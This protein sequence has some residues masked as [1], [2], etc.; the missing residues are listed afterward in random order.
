[1]TKAGRLM[2]IR[3]AESYFRHFLK[4]KTKSGDI[5]PFVMNPP[6]RRL[7]DAIA[8]QNKARKPVRIIILKAR[9]MGFSTESEAQ[10]FFRTATRANVNSLIVAHREDSTTNLFRMSKL[11]YDELPEEVRPMRKSS[12]AQEIIFENPTLDAV[13]KK[14]NPGLRSRIRCVTAGGKGI[15]RSDTITNLHISEYAFWTGDKKE[16]FT[17]LMQ[18]VPSTPESM[19]II[20]STANG[21]D[22][23]KEL[24]DMAVRKESD[25]VPLFFAWWEMPEYRMPVP[26]GTA[27]TA[28]ERELKERYCLNDEQLAWRRWCIK[29]NCGGDETIFR[30]EYPSS[31]EEAFISTGECVFNSEAVRARIESAPEPL[32]VGRFEY[33]YDG[34][35]ISDASI[36]F[37]EDERG[38]IKLYRLPEKGRP[39]V[40]GGDTAGDGSDSFVGQVL[41]NTDGS[42]VAVLRHTYDEDVYARQMYCLGRYYNTALIGIETNYSTYPVKELSRLGYSNMYIREVPDTFTGRLKQAYGF[43]TNLKTRPVIIA[44]LVRTAREDI[45]L[46]CDK[47]TL[48][49]MLTFVYNE[50]RRPEAMAGE[51]DDCVMALAI[52]HYIRPHQKYTSEQK[53]KSR[54]HWTADMWEDYNSASPELKKIIEKKWENID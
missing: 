22:H 11:F 52:A 43:E 27:W 32:K 25:F 30:Q 23:F 41:D 17:G 48:C 14:A 4:I 36:T 2:N 38:E 10:L 37:R 8:E 15:G 19:V 44:N 39:Y 18:A 5:V 47:V 13:E 54:K 34:V 45:S 29:N 1:M 3:H 53:E 46:I 20:E 35:S 16:T 26:P 40:I 49:E 42:Q 9:Q 24:W 31:A 12:T 7:Y 51:H 50:A 33:S 28:E 6:Q 21:Y